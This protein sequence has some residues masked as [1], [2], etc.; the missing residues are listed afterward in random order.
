LRDYLRTNTND[1]PLFLNPGNTIDTI[2]PKS[3]AFSGGIYLP[4]R[5]D[6]CFFNYDFP[7]D[8]NK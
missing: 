2:R 4:L 5:Y 3:T 1:Y 6:D 8:E 7:T